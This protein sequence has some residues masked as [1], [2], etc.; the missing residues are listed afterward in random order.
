MGRTSLDPDRLEVRVPALPAAGVGRRELLRGLV[1]LGAG[2]L[3]V[4]VLG[5]PRRAE[6]LQSPAQTFPDGIKSGDPR[7]RQSVIWTRVPRPPSGA[8]VPVLW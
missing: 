3:L 4:P 5:A 2:A 6:A 8:P 7:P 1:A